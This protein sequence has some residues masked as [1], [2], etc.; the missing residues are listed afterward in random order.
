MEVE[1][2]PEPFFVGED[3]IVGL[4]KNAKFLNIDNSAIRG[5]E[6]ILYHLSIWKRKCKPFFKS[7]G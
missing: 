2:E 4:H 3:L 5:L 6:E 7:L 1:E